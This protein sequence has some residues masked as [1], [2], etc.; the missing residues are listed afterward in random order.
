MKRRTLALHI[1]YKFSEGLC[2]VIFLFFYQL[3]ILY[4]HLKLLKIFVIIRLFFFRL[5]LIYCRKETE[6]IATWQSYVMLFRCPCRTDDPPMADA[7][8]SSRCSYRRSSSADWA[9]WEVWRCR[10][11]DS[12]DCADESSTCRLSANDMEYLTAASGSAVSSSDSSEKFARRRSLCLQ[13]E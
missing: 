12:D 2:V 5:I 7:L 3:N 13:R 6:K 4:I 9:C 10:S 1:K 11:S 8:R